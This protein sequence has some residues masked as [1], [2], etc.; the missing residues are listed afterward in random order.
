MYICM[1]LHCI[2][3]QNK[4]NNNSTMPLSLGSWHVHFFPCCFAWLPCC[5]CWV[6]IISWQSPAVLCCAQCN[7]HKS[8]R[9]DCQPAAVCCMFV[10]P[11]TLP[12]AHPT[13]QPTKHS[14]NLA[15]SSTAHLCWQRNQTTIRF[16]LQFHFKMAITSFS[17]AL[18]CM[19]VA[20]LAS[21][22]L[23]AT[24]VV[25]SL[26]LNWLTGCVLASVLWAHQLFDFHLNWM[27]FVRYSC[28]ILVKFSLLLCPPFGFC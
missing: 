1:Y 21:P 8:C 26:W 3:P 16:Y 27:D 18:N 19:V 2:W 20:A 15:S 28:R 24:A 6:H 25:W 11:L 4:S 23:L 7:C 17:S 22:F 14:N 13:D 10:H 9:S 5:C 12:T